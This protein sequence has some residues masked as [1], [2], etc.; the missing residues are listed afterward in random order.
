[1]PSCSASEMPEVWVASWRMVIFDF[2]GSALQ[3][4]MYFDARSSGDIRPS[5]IATARDIPPT[6]ALAIDAVPCG[7]SAFHSG[8]YHSS[9]MRPRRMTMRPVVRWAARL[10]RNASSFAASSPASAG[11]MAAKSIDCAQARP[12]QA[13][14]TPR[15][16][17]AYPILGNLEDRSNVKTFRSGYSPVWL[18]GDPGSRTRMK[19]WRTILMAAPV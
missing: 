13:E 18:A 1:M 4:A 5:L 3:P 2:R 17:S 10:L 16:S 6:R 8:A 12:A 15:C 19:P 9:A 14:A 7:R 11:E